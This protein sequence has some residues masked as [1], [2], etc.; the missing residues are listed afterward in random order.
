[1]TNKLDHK[2]MSDATDLT[3]DPFAGERLKESHFHPRQAA[4]NLRNACQ[5]GMA[6]S[7]LTIIMM[8][9]TNISVYVM[10]VLLMTFA[11]CKNI[12]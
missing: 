12:S 6:I 2:A 7:L 8:L 5:V 1:M 4:L 11:L 9:S 10:A 3:T